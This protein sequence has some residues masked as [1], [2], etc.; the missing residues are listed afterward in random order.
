MP[1]LVL[2]A[3]LKVREENAHKKR[4]KKNGNII[5]LLFLLFAIQGFSQGGFR[6]FKIV[7]EI[8]VQGDDSW[9]YLSV[10]ENMQRLFITHGIN[11]E[12][13]DIASGLLIGLIPDTPG[14]HGIALVTES[15]K[16]YISCSQDNTVVVIDISS[17][18]VLS[19]IKTGESPDAM[20]YE[21]Y[22]KRIFSFNTK[23]KNSTVID[24]VNDSVVG[25]VLLPGKPGFALAD[26]S[27]NMFVNIEDKASIVKF[28]AKTFKI[29]AEWPMPNETGATGLALD[30]KNK[31]LFSACRDS[32]KLVV[33]NAQNGKIITS[34][35]VGALCEGVIYLP[36][37]KL[38]LTSNR[39]GSMSVIQQSGNF[40]YTVK[41][42]LR[43]MKDARTLT[44]DYSTKT[45]YMPV[46]E[47]STDN[48]KR[49]ISPGT[50]RIL[51]IKR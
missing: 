12:V 33:M 22:S 20:V 51:F 49:R 9:G 26:G 23:G 19:K 40:T 6:E 29:E 31:R 3:G 37:E 25:T 15:G 13:M 10:D 47:V 36:E 27:G 11:V 43:T 24:A 34:V 41:Q 44:C 14:A 32:K 17:L 4:M 5:I 21:P 18:R 7:K 42:T 2:Q 48:G 30:K 28:N 16:G 35:N 8:P 1:A 50:F 38:I 39:D 45:I 46:A